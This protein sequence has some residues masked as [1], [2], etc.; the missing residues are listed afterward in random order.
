MITDFAIA[1]R[2]QIWVL[3]RDGDLSNR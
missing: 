1:Y 2:Q 3:H